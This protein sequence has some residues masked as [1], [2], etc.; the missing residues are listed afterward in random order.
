MAERIPVTQEG[1]EQMRETLHQLT[2][3]ERPQVIKDIASARAHGDLS[4]NAEYSAAKEKQS[5]IEG[6]ISDLK[7]N[8][9]DAD[10][11]E[12][13]CRLIWIYTVRTCNQIGIYEVKG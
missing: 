5:M 6:K 2:T 3:V 10:Q 11:T 8:S 7:V 13:M 9:A 4:E 1:L 12:Q